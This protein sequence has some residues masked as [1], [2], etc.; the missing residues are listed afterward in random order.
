M[1][2]FLPGLDLPESIECPAS[3]VLSLRGHIV[4]KVFPRNGFGPS[5]A[6]SHKDVFTECLTFTILIKKI[7]KGVQVVIEIEMK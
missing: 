7:V 3:A 1:I 6:F 5:F 2:S 4:K